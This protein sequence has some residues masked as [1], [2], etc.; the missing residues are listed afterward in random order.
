MHG[1][2]SSTL[3]TAFCHYKKID[4]NTPPTN[5]L[6]EGRGYSLTF[7]PCNARGL[8]EYGDRVHVM[9]LVNR[10]LNIIQKRFFKS[11]GIDVDED[12][13][14]LSELLQWIWRS[15]I[16][17]GQ[18]INLYIPSRRMRHLLCDWLKIEYID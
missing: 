15:A 14:A 16:R 6:L 9:Y 7:L 11:Y 10:Y 17:N 5:T 8:N 4:K 2:N 12:K 13:F 3:W 18:K 1:N